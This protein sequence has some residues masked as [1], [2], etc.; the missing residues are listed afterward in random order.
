[1]ENTARAKRIKMILM[2]VDGTLTDGSILLLP[3]GEE[4]KSYNVRDGMG[5]LMA[6]LAGLNTGII[7]GKSSKALE[8]R[9]RLLRVDELHQGILNKGP[10]Y[11]TIRKKYSLKSEEVAYIGDDLGDLSVLKV[12]GLAGCVSDAHEE[13]LKHCHFVSRFPGGGGAV[14]EFIEFILASQGLLWERLEEKIA[15]LKG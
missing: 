10:V 12:A 8:K 1:M 2:D 9:A 7:T 11:E 3:D 4:A 13:V 15:N 6:R 14:R 5:M